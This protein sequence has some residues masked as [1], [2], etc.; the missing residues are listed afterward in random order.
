MKNMS[1][2][3]IS[4]L[5]LFGIFVSSCWISSEQRNPRTTK[6]PGIARF[7]SNKN[8]RALRIEINVFITQVLHGYDRT[9]V[10]RSEIN[11]FVLCCACGVG[12]RGPG[13]TQRASSVCLYECKYGICRNNIEDFLV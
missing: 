7:V 8:A 2:T 5:A 12:R 11:D 1:L 4:E 9:A 10:A 6:F 13:S 3:S